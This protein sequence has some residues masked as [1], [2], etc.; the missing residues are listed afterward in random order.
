MLQK[1]SNCTYLGC[2]TTQAR[3]I[4]LDEQTIRVTHAPP[5]QTGFLPDRPWVKDVLYMLPKATSITN[6]WGI[7]CKNGCVHISNELE[8]GYFSEA[9]SVVLQ[10]EG[11]FQLQI[12]LQKEES[13]YG[14]GEWFKEFQRKN[15]SFDLVNKESPAPLQNRQTYS[16][17]PIFYSS[18]GYY[19]FLLNSTPTHW[20]INSGKGLIEVAGKNG[21]VDYI[22]F[23]G[24]DPKKALEAYT[25]LMGRP[26][27][28]PRWAYGLWVTSFPQEDQ[29]KTLNLV[30]KHRQMGIPLDGIIL[31]YHWEEK[32]H[33]FQWRK[34]LF[35]NPKRF[36]QQLTSLGVKLGL[37][38]TPF[39][40]F[41]N[42]FFQKRL[43]ATYNRSIP[44]QTLR[45]D[46]RDINGYTQ[47]V[48]DKFF[49]H[50]NALW[51]FGRGGM[52]DFTNPAA[53]NWWNEKLKPLYKQ[54]IAFFKNDDGEYLPKDASSHI[55]IPADEYHNLYGFYYGK[56]IYEGM[57]ELDN[58]RPL[59]YARSVWAGSQRYP[60]LF[61]G[62]QLPTFEN[63]KR[64]IRAGLNMS[65]LGFAYWTADCFG[66]NGKTSPEL[67]IRYAQWALMVP[68]ARYFVRPPEIDNT[69]FP[70]VSQH[71]SRSQFP[72]A[73]GPPLSTFAVLPFTWLAGLSKRNTN[74]PSSFYGISS[75]QN[76]LCNR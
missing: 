35:P 73:C 33:N 59:I 49:A 15:S 44:K 42:S 66:L 28:V 41:K 43:M 56:A 4:I 38:F 6:H 40:N 12:A 37:I 62:D 14:W 65:L 72:S 18:I 20:I 25:R 60:A 58:R 10:P 36:V 23:F 13:V 64:T 2:R 46:E 45:D 63:L 16:N 55:G 70:V 54:G 11:Q 34:K 30:K 31:D 26:A 24:K 17:I 75:R 71:A 19:F 68:I 22:V 27:L 52:V 32:F 57:Q 21:P 1:T 51:W 39:V 8:G 3:V 29:E 61:L 76:K 74:R 69:R 7:E 50:N 47:G 48:R 9:E 5:E 67:H 53:R